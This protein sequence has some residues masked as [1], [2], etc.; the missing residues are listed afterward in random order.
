MSEKETNRS[1]DI[2][3]ANVADR[4]QQR[5]VRRWSVVL[6]FV[7]GAITLFGLIEV[8][9][10]VLRAEKYAQ[11]SLENK[12]RD[13]VLQTITEQTGSYVPNFE[14]NSTKI[15]SLES[16]MIALNFRVSE[17]EKFFKKAPSSAS[18]EN[19]VTQTLKKNVP[20]GQGW[21]Y[22]GEYDPNR[23][24][25]KRNYVKIDKNKPPGQLAPGTE[26]RIDVDGLNVR[27][28]I[29]VGDVI[30]V[31]NRESVITV[32]RVQSYFL[33]DYFWAKVTYR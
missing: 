31:L 17:L 23:K 7:L 27:D 13:V 25:W 5:L 29:Y 11:S 26:I 6:F 10:L 30:D 8:R 14:K 24:A 21:I 20:S 18:V 1:D 4:A 32:E 12:Y 16:S 2:A 9:H 28:E 22:I 19:Q 33:T 15:G 3:V